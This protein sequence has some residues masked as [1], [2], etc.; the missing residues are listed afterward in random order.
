MD[1]LILQDD[2]IWFLTATELFSSSRG[3]SPETIGALL[4]AHSR[5]ARLTNHHQHHKLEAFVRIHYPLHLL[6][7]RERSEERAFWEI[8]SSAQGM[9]TVHLSDPNLS[10]TPLWAWN[11]NESLA[12]RQ[13]RID[14]MRRMVPE[15]QQQSS[16]TN[17]PLPRHHQPSDCHDGYWRVAELLIVADHERIPFTLCKGNGSSRSLTYLL[18]AHR[19]RAAISNPN[20]PPSLQS[21]KSHRFVACY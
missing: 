14:R 17:G 16:R 19:V 5:A 8:L 21:T 1:T 10:R 13:D 7:A 20:C 4:K 2:S 6:C 18:P 15:L 9:A 11:A 3:A 12:L